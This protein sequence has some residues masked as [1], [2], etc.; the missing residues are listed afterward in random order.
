M[1]GRLDRRFAGPRCEAEH[2]YV[3]GRGPGF[4][5]AQEAALKFKETCGLHAE[6]FSTAEVRHGPMTLVGP[7]FPVFAFVADDASR[8][9]TET[10]IRAFVGQ[11]ATVIAASASPIAGT[12][13]LP[14]IACHPLLQ[15]I[16]HAQSFYRLVERLARCRG[17]DP[18]RPA[19]LNKIT[20]TL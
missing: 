16:V 18:D 7:G 1:G 5:V 17:F 20:R 15:P 14:V 12:V 6:A 19:H 4:G 11:G 8:G 2:L 9:G 10:A 3:V 13:H